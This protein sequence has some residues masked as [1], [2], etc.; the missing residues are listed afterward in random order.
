MDFIELWVLFHGE[1]S[2]GVDVR[3]PERKNAWSSN[4][5][6]TLFVKLPEA[7]KGQRKVVARASF[8]KCGESTN[9]SRTYT[10]VPRRTL[11]E[12]PRLTPASNNKQIFGPSAFGDFE[13][14]RVQKEVEGKGHH[15][16]WVEWKPVSV[17]LNG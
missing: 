15:L 10:A 17:F 11:A 16:F 12:I 7:N 14:Q 1:T 2:F 8:T 13:R 3:I 9:F 5:M 6:E 4:N